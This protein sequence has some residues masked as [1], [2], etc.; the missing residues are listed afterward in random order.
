MKHSVSVQ[1]INLLLDRL[2][3][4]KEIKSRWPVVFISVRSADSW[5]KL[6]DWLAKE[7]EFLK[8]SDFCE[9]S[10]IIPKISATKIKD[11]IT[12]SEQHL[13]LVPFGEWLQ[14][15]IGD[16][17]LLAQDLSILQIP[18]SVKLFVPLLYSEEYLQKALKNVSRWRQGE[19]AQLVRLEE[20]ADNLRVSIV[21]D[22]S[23]P[24]PQGW[25]Q[26]RGL[27][28]YFNYWE[29]PG[30][31]DS[32][33][34]LKTNFA[35]ALLEAKSLRIGVLPGAFEVLRWS[36]SL[37]FPFSSEWGKEENWNWLLKN[38]NA[39]DSID[40]ISRRIFN[41]YN[42]DFW[43]ILEKL[44]NLSDNEKWLFWLWSK[45]IHDDTNPLLAILKNSDNMDDFV[46][47]LIFLPLEETSILKRE[48][49]LLRR[50]AL[51]VM[52]ISRLSS[53]FYVKLESHPNTPVKLRSLIDL[54]ESER[55]KA[56][57]LTCKL[58]EDGYSQEEILDIL[59][60]SFPLL[61]D[62]LF[63]SADL[64]SNLIR[65]Y[66]NAYHTSKV[67]NKA[68]LILLDLEKEISQFEIL[69]DFPTRQKV[70]EDLKIPGRF[71]FWIDGFGIEW[72]D[73]ALNILTKEIDEGYKLDLYVTRVNLPTITDTNKWPDGAEVW[74]EL[75]SEGHKN[76]QYPFSLIRQLDLVEKV[77]KEIKA[78]LELQDS[79]VITA[80]HGFTR[81]EFCKMK[82]FTP[83]KGTKGVHKWGRCAEIERITPE[84]TDPNS[85]W[86]V[87]DR[88]VCLLHH[89]R[90]KK[91]TG[92]PNEVHGGATPEEFLVPVIKISSKDKEPIFHCRAI[93]ERVV[94][95]I[96]NKGTLEIEIFPSPDE[97]EIKFL[98]S[99]K[100]FKGIKKDEGRFIFS[101]E[102]IDTGKQIVVISTGIRQIKR[103]TLEVTG[104]FG[105]EEEDLG[106]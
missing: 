16:P 12:S 9:G 88:W 104:P 39:G 71:Q 34:L 94:L 44:P 41:V 86:V 8:L 99:G 90:F 54:S 62:Y 51:Y 78:R 4:I 26:I 75:D 25:T 18:R 33:I 7:T 21:P 56:V 46:K 63:P 96:R 69:W 5:S 30:R 1:D 65:K 48:C 89:T 91:G 61:R 23:M 38:S 98:K 43:D 47:K 82:T 6:I 84:I 14:L 80:D 27:K 101:I 19:C 31:K 32:N 40:S 2:S 13:T 85:P 103:L 92:A 105:L 28:A 57:D 42:Y 49:L 50:R 58:I 95:D 10:D 70:L 35:P 73:L 97:L 24:V 74:R 64:G 45:T 68:D 87:E 93:S 76:R 59:E 55:K 37:E 83:P 29:T 11:K 52:K 102:D 81:Y 22:I 67:T 77:M 36:L 79:L 60:V 17:D 53:D 66:F 100:T 15:G 3:S 106:I 72:I 20:K